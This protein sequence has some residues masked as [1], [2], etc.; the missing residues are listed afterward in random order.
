MSVD[1]VISNIYSL[2]GTLLL[3]ISQS[4]FSIQKLDKVYGYLL[5]IL[6]SIFMLVAFYRLNSMT[7]FI[8]NF[9]WLLISFYGL[10]LLLDNRK[11]RLNPTLKDNSA[12]TV[13]YLTLALLVLGAIVANI[14][15][16]DSWASIAAVS[17]FV[18]SYTSCSFGLVTQSKY[19]CLSIFANLA[20]LQHL[21][22][23]QNYVTS[24][25]VIIV[26]L[27]ANYGWLNNIRTNKAF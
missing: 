1:V 7:F 16:D 5:A 23:I 24:I 9:F 12:L 14:L 18:I 20:S 27:I 3:T 6:G 26:V 10:I 11:S 21:I 19:I 17:I 4:A 15:G 13:L 2:I 25:Q 22:A 8:F